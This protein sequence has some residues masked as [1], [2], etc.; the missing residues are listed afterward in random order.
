MLEKHV[1]SKSTFMRSCQCLKSLY[2]HK[3]QPNLKDEISES[4]ETIF[5]RGTNVGLLAQKLFPNG[6]DAS[7]ATPYE[8]QKSVEKTAQLIKSGTGIIYEAAFQF[9]GVLC[10][11]DILVKQNDIWK[12]Y[13]VKWK[14]RSN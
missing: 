9:E 8:Y 2:L 4:Q 14:N 13:E 6:V 12:A 11:I 1:L 3:F 10:A 7:P 5:M